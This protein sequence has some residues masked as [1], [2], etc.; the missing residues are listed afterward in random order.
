MKSSSRKSFLL[1]CV[2][3]LAGSGATASAQVQLEYN[4]P[5]A[6][7]GVLHREHHN[8]WLGLLG[9][10][11]EA[12]KRAQGW[13]YILRLPGAI[14]VHASSPEDRQWLEDERGIKEIFLFLPEQIDGNSLVGKRVLVKGTLGH[15]NTV[16]H[17]RPITME[18]SSI[19]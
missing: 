6:L 1:M 2:A 8:E 19:E 5:V 16:H 10:T 4:S 9:N 17:L 7:R 3:V 18:V 11:A 12:R 13:A 14:D 15:A